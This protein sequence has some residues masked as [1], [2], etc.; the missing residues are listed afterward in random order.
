MLSSLTGLEKIIVFLIDSY[1][2]FYL[3]VFQLLI[4]AALAAVIAV[5]VH[6]HLPPCPIYLTLSL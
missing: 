1:K 4:R 6:E 3:C 2:S 5:C